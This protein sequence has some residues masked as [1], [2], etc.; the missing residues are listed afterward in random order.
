MLTFYNSIYRATFLTVSTIDALSHINIVSGGPSASVLT[1]FRLNSDSLRRTDSL[2]QLACNASLLTSRVTAQGVLTTEPRRY[3]SLFKGVV[4]G[5]PMPMVV[6]CLYSCLIMTIDTIPLVRFA[7]AIDTIA[8]FIQTAER[9]Y[10][11]RPK[12]LFQHD[13]HAAEKL[14]HEKV[15]AGFI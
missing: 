9:G 12:E 3:G 15:L 2:A 13:V 4:D 8:T 14:G 1:F 5:I 7:Y 6:R 10:S 11:R